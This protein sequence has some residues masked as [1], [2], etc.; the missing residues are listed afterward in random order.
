MSPRLTLLAIA[1]ALGGSALASLVLVMVGHNRRPSP[2]PGVAAPGV[3]GGLTPAVGAAARKVQQAIAASRAPGRDPVASASLAPTPPPSPTP[4][5]EPAWVEGDALARAFMKDPILPRLEA[6]GQ[7]V[8]AAKQLSPNELLVALYEPE[9]GALSNWDDETRLVLYRR[10][11][12]GF[13]RSAFVTKAGQSMPGRAVGLLL[14]DLDGDRL[15]EA[16]LVGR[17]QGRLNQVPSLG[18]RRQ[19]QGQPF[20]LFWKHSDAGAALATTSSGRFLAYLHQ[21]GGPD[22]P[23]ILERYGLYGGV[24]SV[25]DRQSIEPDDGRVR[26]ADPPPAPPQPGLRWRR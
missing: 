22:G 18:L 13:E 8:V 24:L 20:Q 16:F 3:D 4:P 5:P 23:W 7:E 14:T 9:R 2:L 10:E 6:L 26:S 15:S 21:E 25:A 12:V 11:A 1:L 17:P 19:A